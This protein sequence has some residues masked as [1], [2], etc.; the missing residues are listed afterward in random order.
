MMRRMGR[1]LVF[2]LG[3]AIVLGAG[4]YYASG[5]F[6]P[7]EK[8]EFDPETV[9]TLQNVRNAADQSEKDTNQRVDNLLEKSK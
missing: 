8:G 4:Y 9:R 3:A 5:R 7:D 1:I 2:I 6:V